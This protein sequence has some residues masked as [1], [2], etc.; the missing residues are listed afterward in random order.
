MLHLSD[1]HVQLGYKEGEASTCGKY[2]VCCLPGLGVILTIHPCNFY[3]YSI[4]IILS[5]CS[6]QLECILSQKFTNFDLKCL[7]FN[8]KAFFAFTENEH[9]CLL[10]KTKSVIA[11]HLDLDLDLDIIPIIT[12]SLQCIAGHLI[13]TRSSK[14]GRIHLRPSSLD[15]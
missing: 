15:S 5:R 13:F 9:C 1:L 8:S 14:V 2:P 11:G 10:T 12:L 4:F 7:S 6:E 3:R